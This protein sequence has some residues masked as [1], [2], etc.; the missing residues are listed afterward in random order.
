MK[1]K[2]PHISDIKFNVHKFT[3]RS[4]PKDKRNL[5]IFPCF[6]EFGTE[7][8]G[9]LYC[10]PKMMGE[11][12]MGKYSIVM[13]WYGRAY[14]YK[15]LVD[16]FWEIKEEF[17]W[18]REY[19]RAFYH[20]SVNLRRLEDNVSQYGKVVSH[21]EFGNIANYPRLYECQKCRGE[22]SEVGSF[23]ACSKCNIVYPGVGIFKDPINAIKEA[24]WLPNPS[25]EKVKLVSKY[26]KPNSIGIT[27][28]N[29]QTYGRNLPSIFYERL[30]YLIEDMGYNPIWI[31]EKQTIHSCPFS[32][33]TDFSTM[34]EANDLESTL[35][36]VSQLK[37]TIQFWTAST[38]LAGLVGTPYILFESPD[39]LFGGTIT[40]GHEG[41]R[42]FLCTRG[43]RKLVVSHF[44]DL[45]D[46][47]N[48]GLLLSKQAIRGVEVGDYTEIIAVPN[49]E[50]NLR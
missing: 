44:R 18:L 30:I 48:K 40:P 1:S 16:E 24:R 2:E 23:Q 25:V 12:Y 11:K 47:N 42:L 9:V 21:Y 3:K 34:P 50:M 32:R 49:E 26:L 41:Y 6:S 43:P 14:L 29:R 28:R 33:I 31:G 35:A 10:I 7:I 13:G 4:K 46:D 37:Y 45:S 8:L 36:L 20:H 17:Q 27:A 38:R 39:Q 5:V 22:V 15:H 19:C